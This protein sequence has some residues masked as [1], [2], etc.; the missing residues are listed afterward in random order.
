VAKIKVK[1]GRVVDYTNPSDTD[2]INSGDLVLD[3][4]LIGIALSKILPKGSDSQE[5]NITDTGAVYR[6]GSW[7]LP[8]SI[9]SDTGT[10]A[11]WS[12]AYWDSG[13]SKVVNTT[14]VEIGCFTAAYTTADTEAIILLREWAV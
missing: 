12:T 3:G 6:G 1:D 13:E 10:V 11:A 5:Y 9:T 8:C 4:E 2:T 7:T 14:G